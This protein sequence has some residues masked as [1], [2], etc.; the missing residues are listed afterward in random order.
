MRAPTYSRA[1]V[2]AVLITAITLVAL[3]LFGGGGGDY[4]VT[5]RFINAG[6]IVK[7][8]PVQ[9]GGV[10]IG[11]VREIELTPGGQADL[12]LLYTSPSPRDRS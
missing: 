8:N 10:P 12:C 11:S 5:A 1:I 6:Q 9:A 3:A 4:T 2:L 7:G